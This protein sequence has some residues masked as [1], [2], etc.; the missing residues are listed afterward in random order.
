MLSTSG[1]KE[2]MEKIALPLNEMHSSNHCSIAV[3]D[4]KWRR[5]LHLLKVSENLGEFKSVIQI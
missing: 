5:V 3:W 2:V 4:K 1:L